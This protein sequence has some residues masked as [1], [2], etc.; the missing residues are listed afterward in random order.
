MGTIFYKLNEIIIIAAATYGPSSLISDIPC[1]NHS[2]K[3]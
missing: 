1:N 3:L 2:K